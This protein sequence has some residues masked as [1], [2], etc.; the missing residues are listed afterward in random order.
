MWCE[1]RA[2]GVYSN[3][4]LLPYRETGASPV[5]STPKTKESPRETLLCHTEDPWCT[6]A[7]NTNITKK[8]FFRQLAYPNGK[9][10]DVIC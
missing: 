7:V 10:S 2:C 9:V 4:L 1:T 8:I 5:G 6:D 3:M